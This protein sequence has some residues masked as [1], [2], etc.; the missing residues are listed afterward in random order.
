MPHPRSTLPRVR[1]GLVRMVLLAVS[2]A[3]GPSC[4]RAYE[5][6]GTP[7][8]DL[9]TEEGPP[10]VHDGTR[11][12]HDGA[13]TVHDSTPDG[14]PMDLQHPCANECTVDTVASTSTCTGRVT[15]LE[16]SA[17]QGRLRVDLAG[18]TALRLMVAI[19]DP[20]GWVLN[21][22]NSPGNDGYGGDAGEFSND[23]ELQLMGTTL[24]VYAN[25]DGASA[26]LLSDA[27]F[28]PASGCVSR[29]V[30]VSDGKVTT[31]APAHAVDSPYVFRLNQPDSTGTPDAVIYIGLNR[32]V[33]SDSPR[34]GS[35]LRAA[36]VCLW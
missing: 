34:V 33:R 23:S 7:G 29:E 35:G 17:G 27:S 25:D 5:V 19:C 20:S 36:S 15:A 24:S 8:A 26:Q 12:V 16:L 9:A 6:R 22:G 2:C 28:V 18:L 21:V 32:V 3:A 13:P 31:L 14:S 1:W 30:E 11:A 10:S 4:V